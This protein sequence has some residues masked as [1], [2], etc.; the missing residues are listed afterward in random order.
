MTLRKPSTANMSCGNVPHVWA[1]RLPAPTPK[2][3]PRTRGGINTRRWH[4]A[5]HHAT[6]ACTVP[7]PLLQPCGVRWWH[8]RPRAEN[9]GPDL[10]QPCR[11]LLPAQPN[12]TVWLHTCLIMIALQA[13]THTGGRHGRLLLRSPGPILRR[14]PRTASAEEGTG[15]LDDQMSFE[16]I[17]T[18]LPPAPDA[19]GETQPTPP[20]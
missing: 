13:A 1:H 7:P 20:R 6:S 2:T 4:T 3:R 10:R 17:P 5:L 18:D 8:L 11:Y 19:G 14:H 15:P 12:S 16:G 9:P